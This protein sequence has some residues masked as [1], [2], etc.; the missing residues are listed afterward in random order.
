MGTDQAWPY[1]RI[2]PGPVDVDG[3]L[4]V[5]S[6]GVPE[7]LLL[8]LPEV[9]PAGLRA[10]AQRILYQKNPRAH[11]IRADF[12]EP[13]G[14]REA[15]KCR[16]V[17]IAAR[18]FLSLTCRAITLT[19]GAILKEEKIPLLWGR[20]NLGGIL[21]GNLGEGN[22]ESKIG[23]RQWRVNFGRQAFRCLAG[24]SGKGMRRSTSQ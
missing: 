2:R 17:K 21:R 7:N 4:F 8:V 24:P 14:P 23:A 5:D 1:Q 16:E 22:C 15:S 19:A 3:V 12:W 18:Q 6:F 13:R 20:G 10:P 11:I 9:A